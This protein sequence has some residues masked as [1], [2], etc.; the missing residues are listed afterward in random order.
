MS[1]LWVRAGLVAGGATLAAG[2]ATAAFAATS[3]PSRPSGPDV[4]PGGAPAVRT[5]VAPKSGCAIVLRG[6]KPGNVAAAKKKAAMA[7][8]KL[9]VEPGKPGKPGA[10]GKP[11][12]PGKPKPPGKP[13]DLGPGNKKGC[14]GTPVVLKGTVAAVHVTPGG[15]EE[16][17]RLNTGKTTSDVR[18]LRKTVLVKDGRP[19]TPGTL[20]SLAAGQHVVVKGLA[21]GGAKTPLALVIVE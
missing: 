7:R 16:T 18:V 10:P 21:P 3:G 2:A 5:T 19:V 13:G 4:T 17:L 8:A 9:R 15:Q 14:G 11:K 6:V 20:P 12:G 1:S